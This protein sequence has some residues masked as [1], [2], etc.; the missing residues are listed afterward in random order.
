MN[1]KLLL[2]VLLLIC[3]ETALIAAEGE[4]EPKVFVLYNGG[5]RSPDDVERF[6]KECEKAIREREEEESRM[7]IYRG[8]KNRIRNVNRKIQD[9]SELP[10]GETEMPE[11][12]YTLPTDDVVH[13][14]KKSGEHKILCKELLKIFRE[15]EEHYG[16]RGD[17]MEIL[18]DA[19]MNIYYY[20][21]PNYKSDREVI[22]YA[23][24]YLEWR[25]WERP[26]RITNWERPI[27]DIE[28]IARRAWEYPKYYKK[29]LKDRKKYL[30]RYLE[31][32]EQCRPKLDLIPELEEEL[33]NFKGDLHVREV[34]IARNRVSYRLHLLNDM[35]SDMHQRSIGFGEVAAYLYAHTSYSE[36]D[37]KELQD[38]MDRYRFPEEY[39]KKAF[40]IIDE[41]K[42][43]PTPIGG[44]F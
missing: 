36:K 43:C 6:N 26:L 25:I 13:K 11:T 27:L 16:D 33:R 17:R 40:K 30:E 8:F 20:M 37:M 5:P 32:L 31:I 39:R 15:M 24:P 41:A 18:S 23:K 2:P 4:E 10:E 7:E 21:N 9:E 12:S 28:E 29:F 34:E 1:M 35:K 14:R 42:A 44:R 3:L 22:E 19:A 38:L